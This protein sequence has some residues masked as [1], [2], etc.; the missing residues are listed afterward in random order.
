MGEVGDGGDI[1]GL[2]GVVLNSGEKKEGG[3]VGM[4]RYYLKDIFS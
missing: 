4:V 2:A 3:R 1:E